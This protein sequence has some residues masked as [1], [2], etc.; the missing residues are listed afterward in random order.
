MRYIARKVFPC[1]KSNRC[2]RDV[3]PVYGLSCAIPPQ[4]SVGLYA[5]R[6]GCSVVCNFN[7]GTNCLEWNERSRVLSFHSSRSNPVEKIQDTP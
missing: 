4:T 6:V 2:P 3:T 1:D 5:V 7:M